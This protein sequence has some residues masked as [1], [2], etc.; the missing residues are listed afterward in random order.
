MRIDFY[1]QMSKK[2]KDEKN[3]V[4]SGILT[5]EFNVAFDEAT[6]QSGDEIREEIATKVWHMEDKERVI[7]DDMKRPEKISNYKA[8]IYANHF[9]REEMEAMEKYLQIME[10]QMRS[11]FLFKDMDMDMDMVRQAI[12]NPVKGIYFDK[13]DDVKPEYVDIIINDYAQRLEAETLL[14]EEM[15]LI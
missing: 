3:K 2:L 8:Q 7:E 15:H 4:S 11:R 6:L 5:D 12:Y 10:T 13:N 14:G 9:A 1:E